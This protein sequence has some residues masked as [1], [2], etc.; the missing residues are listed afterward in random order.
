MLRRCCAFSAGFGRQGS[1][2]GNFIQNSEFFRRL[3][4]PLRECMHPE[5][6]VREFTKPLSDRRT[7]TP[8]RLPAN[9]EVSSGTD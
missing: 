7:L 6:I 4:Y 9:A 1:H 8:G 3:F 2:S 5:Q